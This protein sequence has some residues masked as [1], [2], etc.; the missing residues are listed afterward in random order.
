MHNYF[1]TIVDVKEIEECVGHAYLNGATIYHFE[2]LELD[3]SLDKRY[4][5]DLPI[6]H[7]QEKLRYLSHFLYEIE[8]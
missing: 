4:V 2:K 5:R 6:N 8:E 1:I 3:I 7:S